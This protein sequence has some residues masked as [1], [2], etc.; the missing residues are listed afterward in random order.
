MSAVSRKRP[1]IRARRASRFPRTAAIVG[2]DLDPVEELVDALAKPR[3]GGHRLGV[4]A[5]REQRLHP[6]GDLRDPR[7]EAPFGRL[8]EEGRV[9]LGPAAGHPP[10][11]D[12]VHLAQDVGDPL[13]GRR[14]ARRLRE[15]PERPHRVH[16]AHEVE[17]PGGAAGVDRREDVGRRVRPTAQALHREL[18]DLARERLVAGVEDLAITF[19]GVADEGLEVRV[20]LPLD[21]DP[22]RPEGVSP[23]R[24]R[25][26]V[27]GRAGA[28]A[29]DAGKGVEPFREGEGPPGRGCGDRVPREA[30]QV[31]LLDRVRDLV[32]LPAR[33]CV[34]RAHV[35]L[36]VRELADH[37]GDE[38]ALVE[39]GRA[40]RGGGLVRVEPGRARDVPGEGHH[41][42]GLR[43]HRAEPLLEHDP[44][45]RGPEGGQGPL[46]V[47]AHEKLGVLEAGPN[48]PLVAGPDRVRLPALDV[49]EGDE[50]SAQ[51]PVL[52]L[53]REVALVTLQGGRDHPAREVEEALLEPARHRH[54]PLDEGG[55]LVEEVVARDRPAAEPGRRVRDEALDA[56]AALGEGGEHA[57]RLAELLHVLAG[58]GKGDRLRM[59][60]AVAAGLAA[61]SDPEDG[62]LDDLGP[63]EEDDPVD[64][65][66]ELRVARA[67]AHAPRDG[68]RGEG[69]LDDPRD[70][71]RGGAG[72]LLGAVHEPRPLRGLEPAEVAHLHPAGAGEPE[73][74]PGRLAGIV[75]R[76]AKGRPPAFPGPAGNALRHPAH[77]D[78]EAPGGREGLD[79]PAGEPGPREPLADRGRERLGEAAQGLGRELL[80]ADLREEVAMS[81]LGHPGP[82]VPGLGRPGLSHRPPPSRAR[83]RYAA[84]GSRAARAGRARRAPRPARWCAR[85]GGSAGARSP[86]APP[87]HRGG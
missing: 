6:R 10:G 86:R 63:E 74:G 60:E 46:A 32:R 37:G 71:L 1:P 39:L 50:R 67:P 75:E 47:G 19:D 13:V 29:E 54:R 45:E 66:H 84:G 40:H 52:V 55:H 23:E 51:P 27:P 56:R 41:P 33:P 4:V 43:G 80:G 28:D 62:G 17:G 48:H 85:E 31:R 87:A 5:A 34:A 81:G 18:E 78:G 12:L 64:R 30:R 53:D 9:H 69:R 72:R 11:V 35:P 77:D 15:R 24:E 83:P 21:E 26:A 8:G 2:H 57:P 61:G 25:I 38:V 73:G 7:R 36:E 70:E 44:V 82:G 65:A 79:H 20:D 3:E 68:Q 14:E 59:V 42:V 22:E 49:A 76:P 16:P 58:L